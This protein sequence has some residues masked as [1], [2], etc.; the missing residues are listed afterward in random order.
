LCDVGANETLEVVALFE[1]LDIANAEEEA[2]ICEENNAVDA[3]G[4]CEANGQAGFP[5]PVARKVGQFADVVGNPVDAPKI[6]DG[7]GDVFGVV[8]SVA[9][10]ARCEDEEECREYTCWAATEQCADAVRGDD[11]QKTEGDA[12]EVVGIVCGDGQD[13]GKDMPG[14]VNNAAVEPG[15]GGFKDVLIFKTTL[16]PCNDVPAV[17]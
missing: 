16:I 6:K 13:L 9:I 17:V 14:N 1:K 3:T 2:H 11:A 5:D 8:E 12:A 10:I 4:Q 7:K 15:I